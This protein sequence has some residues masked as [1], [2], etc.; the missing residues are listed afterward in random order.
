MKWILTLISLSF[1]SL[2]FSQKYISVASKVGFFSEAPIENITAVNSKSTSA[3]DISNGK[4][5]FSVPIQYFVFDKSLMQEHFND[6]YMESDKFP[7][8]TFVG[9]INNF[10]P[11][12]KEEQKV[13]AK[14]K[15]LIHGIEKDVSVEGTIKLDKKSVVID[16]EFFVRLEDYGIKIPQIVWQNI[17]EEIKIKIHFEYEPFK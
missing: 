12:I 16:S 13:I 10:N 6:Q 3:I 4:M 7:K 11:E 15:L 8:S 5:A 9:Q 1:S 14:G 2:L 17:A